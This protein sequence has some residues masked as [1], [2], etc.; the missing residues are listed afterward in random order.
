VAAQ[1]AGTIQP[2]NTPTDEI[3]IYVPS[4]SASALA[5]RTQV[6]VAE[7]YGDESKRQ[8]RM[9]VLQRTVEIV[10]KGVTTGGVITGK[11][12]IGAGGQR[13]EFGLEQVG[14]GFAKVDQRKIDYGEASKLLI[15]AQTAA[16]KNRVGLWSLE[17]AQPEEKVAAPK[18][19]ET[20]I[21]VTISEI[22]SGRHFFFQQYG[23]E[24]VK[25]IDE[26]MK[27]F[28]EKNGLK[29][30]PCD[31]KVN[32][33]VAALFDDGS[34]KT[35]Y[36]AKIIERKV[37]HQVTVLFVDYGNTAVVPVATH[38]RP[39]DS[40]L[41]TVRIP[42][43]A[44]EAQLALIQVRSIDDDDGIDAAR[45]FSQIGFGKKLT[46][47]IHCAL[48]GKHCVTLLDPDDESGTSINEELVTSGMAL[49]AKKDEFE[50]M[51][52][53]MTDNSSLVKLSE[54]IATAQEI[55]RKN[56]IGM[57]R[58]GDIGEEDDDER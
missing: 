49:S 15:D 2:T 52:A 57:W 9:L 33:V 50:S 31:I 58:Y 28:S 53:K 37:R 45:M 48:D 39:L 3:L 43:V 38:L 25:V 18:A 56:R 54:D 41:E 34:G 27:L 6:K 26:S 16:Q 32:K 11:L 44:K 23:S 21:K 36:R 24:A 42:P 30:G 40:A 12:F 20:E 13:R 7:P 10:C 47:R 14:A 46:A 4:P 29:A 55:A 17:K 22:R 19:K 1:L 35:W 5:S 8:A 51:S